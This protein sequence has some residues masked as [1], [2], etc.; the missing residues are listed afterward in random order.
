VTEAEWLECKI[1]RAMQRLLPDMPRLSQRTARLF[2]V[3]VVALFGA[4]WTN[5]ANGPSK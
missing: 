4:G 3:V 1:P 2:A 5:R